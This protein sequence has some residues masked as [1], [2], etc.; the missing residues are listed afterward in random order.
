MEGKSSKMLCKFPL[1]FHIPTLNTSRINSISVLNIVFILQLMGGRKFKE[2][3]H[4]I[5]SSQKRRHGFHGSDF[6][7]KKVSPYS[8]ITRAR[9]HVLNSTFSVNTAIIP[10]PFWWFLLLVFLFVMTDLSNLHFQS[11]V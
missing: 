1:S 10:Y 2:R 11:T 5:F 6:Y 3:F 8:F 7:G 4:L 9:L